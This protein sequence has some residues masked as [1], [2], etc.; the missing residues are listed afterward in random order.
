MVAT[1]LDQ[2]AKSKDSPLRFQP[3]DTA[4]RQKL[5]QHGQEVQR[6]REERQKLETK[7]A[8]RPAEKPSK[9]FEPAR[10]RLPRSPIVAKPVA[11]LGKDHAP[12][13][14]YEA[15]APDPKVAPKP[16]GN[17]LAPAIPPRVDQPQPQPKV[18]RPTGLPRAGSKEDTRKGKD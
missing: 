18:D 8:V 6:F 17:R 10:V 4:E 5:A 12:P 7:A 3:V 11:E 16:R 15:P 9:E 1:P 14:T 2:L 13:K